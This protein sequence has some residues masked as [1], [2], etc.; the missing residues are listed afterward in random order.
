MNIR[1]TEMARW[2]VRLALQDLI[3]RRD[4]EAS[5]FAQALRSLFEEP[6][7]IPDRLCPVEGMSELPHQEVVL[8]SYRL[9]FLEKEETL[10]F[11]GLWPPIYAN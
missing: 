9:L 8:G 10:W 4:P 1:V 11:L 7:T 5:L 6:K 3:K 2:Q